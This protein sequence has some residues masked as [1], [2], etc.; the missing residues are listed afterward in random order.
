MG[1]WSEEMQS[2][3]AEGALGTTDG[4]ARARYLQGVMKD[5]YWNEAKSFLLWTGA[6]KRLLDERPTKFFFSTVRGR[7]RRSFI[8]GLRKDGGVETTVEGMLRI[9][10]G[11]YRELF[12]CR[13]STGCSAEKFLDALEG[14]LEE[15]EREALEGPL[16]LQEVGSAISSLKGG[17]APGC[18]GLPSEFYRTVLPWIGP[19][20]VCVYQES[21]GRG[22]L[23][24]K[25]RTG[26]VALLHKKG[27]KEELTNWRPITLLTTDYKVLAKVITERLKKVIG[28]VVQPDQTCGVPGRSG[29]LNL[30][31]VRDIL[32]WGEQRQLSLAI[33]SLDQEKAFDRV[34]HAFLMAI[35]VRM[36]FGPVFRSWV[37]LL[38]SRVS[39]RVGI[40]GYYSGRV[41]Q[42]GGV[43]QGC[44][45]SPLLYVLSLEPLMAALRAAESLTG[46]HL[47]GSRGMNAKVSA[48]ADDMTLFLTS[49]QDFETVCKI[50]K[51]FF[52]AS[53]AR[54]IVD[55]SSAMFAGRWADRTVVPGG[56][57][58]CAEGLKILGIRFFRENSA[59]QNW[60][61][62][63]IA[64]QAKIARWKLRGL[65]MWG[66]AGSSEGRPS[67]EFE[68]FG[69]HFSGTLL[70]R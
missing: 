55:K 26:L 28:V 14:S 13:G 67:S 32:F 17:M 62:K 1:R 60:E 23:P 34:S 12:N 65:S 45:L 41:E 18:D 20:L 47:P 15:E 42:L 66:R 21:I 53:G 19:E 27:P 49:D 30:A 54:A 8:E 31:L 4:R 16:S 51:S 36:G 50:L 39:S 5:F 11:F 25:M 9:A 3:W 10:E 52:E 69:L 22:E 35:L 56:Y 38:Y 6:Q 40:N 43:R 57:N 68:L 61:A 29:G 37:K 59:Q 44:P 7:Q 64:V 70:V 33:L 48:Y 58:L 63:F 2:L 46:M 24:L